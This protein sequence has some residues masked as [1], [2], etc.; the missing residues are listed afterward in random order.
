MA[1][2]QTLAEDLSALVATHPQIQAK[3]KATLSAAEAIR[4]ARA[5]YLPTVKAAGDTGPEWIDNK[6]R[7]DAGND[8]FYEGRETVGLTVTQKL[9]D[10]F[11]TD[12]AVEAAK[13][14]QTIAHA[15]LRATRQTTMLEGTLAY[16]NVLRYTKLIQLARDNERKVQE[17]LHL[18][19]ERVQKGAGIASDVLDAKQRLQIS[20]EKR[21]AYEGSFQDA[22]ATYTQV[23]GRA[24]DV[25]GLI[26]P[27]IPADLIPGSL[28]DALQAAEKDNPTLESASRAIELSSE[29]KR[30]AE[31]GYY[32]TLDLIGKTNYENDK[33]ATLDTRRDWSLL[34]TANWELFSGFK[35]DAQVAQATYDHAASKD[36]QLHTGRKVAEAVRKAWH[37]LKV[38][39][40]RAGLLENAA[41]LAEEVWEARKKQRDAGKA[42]VTEVLDQ[43]TRVDDARINYTMAYYDTIV[44]SY[45]LLTAMGRFEV[46]ALAPQPMPALQ[47][48]VAPEPS[49]KSKRETRAAAP[50]ATTTTTAVR[51]D[52]TMPLGRAV[53]DDAEMRAHVERL[54]EESAASVVRPGLVYR[55]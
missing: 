7:R 27:V 1:P 37:K 39:R 11:A 34:L 46:D 36:N 55:R 40:E 3:Q 21:V 41:V 25:A 19:D 23:Y 2:A 4:A 30:T 13:V 15:E 47:P 6:T 24:P 16:V 10:G 29:R 9:F 17:Q 28:D 38:A 43:E 32:P 31:A 20:K 14:S 8:A 53:V 49:P 45:E 48:A 51:E 26:D 54:V 42:T 35:T 22:V 52:L 18:E 44:A 50:A 12:S 33:N 5:G